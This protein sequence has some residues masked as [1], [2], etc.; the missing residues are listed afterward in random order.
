MMVAA[1]NTYYNSVNFA[2]SYQWDDEGRMTSLQYPTVS[3]TGSFG[4]MP[5]NMPIAAMQYDVNGRLNAMTMDDRNG[6]GPQP[7]ASAS[8]YP[9]GQLYTLQ[10]EGWTE[11][12]TYNNL[13]Q[14]TNQSVP[15]TL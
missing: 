2:A 8:Y 9:T 3:A 10:V 15:Y 4:N 13:M 14:L 12:R 5:A 1:P 7:F 6:Q 11:T